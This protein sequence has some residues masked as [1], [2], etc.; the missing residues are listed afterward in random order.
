MKFALSRYELR[1]I[2]SLSAA[3]APGPRAGALI[4]VEH[5][6]GPGYA[7]LHPWPELGDAPLEEQLR[8]LLT[9]RPLALAERALAISETDARA[10]AEGRSLFEGLEVPESHFLCSDIHSLSPS[11]LEG[12]ARQGFTRV[13]VKAGRDTRAEGRALREL[14]RASSGPVLFR[15]DF[16]A[17]AGREELLGFVSE[18][19]PAIDRVDFLEDPL[20]W[21]PEAWLELKRLTGARLALDRAAPFGI[22]PNPAVDL[23]VI[24]PAAQDPRAVPREACGVPRVYTSYLDHPVGQAAAAFEAAA[25]VARGET[26]EACGLLSHVVYEPSTFSGTL[27]AEGPRFRAAEGAG[28]GFAELLPSLKWERP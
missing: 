9:S 17:K 5:P 10:R 14:A 13:K 22:S 12:L 3:A 11:F 8:S 19:G 25:A 18:A 4:R 28:L 26:V 2:R 6:E 7:D 24:K 20:P 27:C 23:L 16:N 15:L 21:D 1:P